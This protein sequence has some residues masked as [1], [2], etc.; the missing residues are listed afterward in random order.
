[1][2]T[3]LRVGV[4]RARP[5]RQRTW[6][7]RSPRARRQTL[8]AYVFLSPWITGFLIFIAY[9]IGA[10]LYYSLTKYP[11]LGDISWVGLKNYS[12]LLHD[13]LFWQS[14]KV[15]TAYSLIAVPGSIALGYGIAL[16]LNQ[17]VRWVGVWRTLYFLPSIVPA[18]ATAYLWSWI[19][20]PDYGLVNAGLFSLHLPRPEWFGSTTWVLP[21]F[22]LMTLWGSGGNLVLYLAALQQVPTAL[23]EAAHIDGAGAWNRFVH[24]TVPMTSPVLLFTF[25]TGV[26]GSFQIFTAAYVITRGGPDNASLFY[27]VYLFRTGWQYFQ[28]GY[29]SALAWVLLVM[30]LV[31]TL[32]TLRVSRRFVY[33]DYSD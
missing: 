9:P 19:L 16:L 29:A 25:L 7:W 8:A 20:N 18:I 21:A 33:Y 12:V 5:G 28:M 4:S 26:I 27:V 15:T 31:L 14:L 2:E 1:M 6:W 32:I 3:A 24:I 30:M 13:A 22:I 10:T 23:Y 11:I 17:K